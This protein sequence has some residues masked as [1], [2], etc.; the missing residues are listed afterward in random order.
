MKR[1]QKTVLVLFLLRLPGRMFFSEQQVVSES[2]WPPDKLPPA[3]SDV[4]TSETLLNPLFIAYLIIWIILLSLF[5]AVLVDVMLKFVFL[6][7][8]NWC[9]LI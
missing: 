4:A 5:V 6:H 8:C 2:S 1:R 9:L 7:M 3:S